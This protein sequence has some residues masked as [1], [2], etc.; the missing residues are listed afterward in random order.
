MLLGY[1]TEEAYDKL[2]HDISQNAEQYSSNEEWLQTY[3][4]N[5]DNYYKMSS[6]DVSRFNP[7]YTPGKKMMNKSQEK[8]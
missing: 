5:S 1:F 6:V 2:L 4:G 7:Y 3:F 8:I